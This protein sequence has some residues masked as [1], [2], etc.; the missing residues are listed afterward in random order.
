[1]NVERIVEHAASLDTFVRIDMEESSRVDVTLLIYRNLRGSGHD[2][3]GVVLQSYLYRTERDLKML[4]EYQPN[5]RIVKGAYLE[6]PEVAY[7]NKRDV[8][9]AYLRA[10]KYALAYGGYTA[11]ATHDDR[12]IDYVIEYTT[13][14][15]ISQDK[16]EFQML[17]G[18]RTDLQREL[19]ERGY[20]VLIA[21]P[22]GP[23]W[24]PYLMR[25]MAERPANLLFVAR[26]MLP[27]A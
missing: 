1:R 5:L 23:D 6:P 21:T 18:I 2:N 9:V 25:R 10:A 11:I 7:P 19:L 13:R 15:N 26:Q 27:G 3:V 14:N 24:Y 4:M 20:K 17:Y 22:F 8:D 12:I 16:F